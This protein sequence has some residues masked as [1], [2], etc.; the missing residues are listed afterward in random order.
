[1]VLQIESQL[2]QQCN[3][4][5]VYCSSYDALEK[6]VNDVSCY[7]P[8]TREELLDDMKI[9]GDDILTID[10]C[11]ELLHLAHSY[12]AD[13]LK[14]KYSMLCSIKLESSSSINVLENA[15]KVDEFELASEAL[16][17]VR[18]NIT[19]LIQDRDELELLPNAIAAMLD[20]QINT[21]QI[22]KHQC[23]ALG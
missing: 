16:S 11:L 9:T 4:P 20:M 23:L 19:H 14:Q 2:K 21:E 22:Q 17:I 13:E 8:Q 6:F 18:Q 5:V 15:V 1:M 12:S 3:L 10:E 7:E